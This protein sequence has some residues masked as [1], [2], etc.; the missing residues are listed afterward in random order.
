MEQIRSF[1]AVEL[2]GEAKLA[3]GRVQEQLKAGGYA[4]AKWVDPGSMH[5][6]LKFLGNI[7]AD[8]VGGIMAALRESIGGI[9]PFSLGISGLGAFPG[10]NRVQIVWAGVTGDV[11]RLRRLQQAVESQLSPLGFAPEKR[12]FSPH[13]T[14]ARLRDQ[15][16]P[17]ERRRLGQAIAGT[18]FK[19]AVSLKVE[20]VHLMRS[21]LTPQGAVYS[22]LGSAELK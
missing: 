7:G 17:E 11:D 21:Q 16:A 10:L 18:E 5:L 1:I 9:V 20:A 22:R 19:A 15:A 4:P 3:I 8:S 13:L 6:T 12:A 2:P 14:L